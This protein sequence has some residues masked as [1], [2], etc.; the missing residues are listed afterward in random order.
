MFLVNWEDSAT[1]DFV[2]IC[3]DY[4][5]YWVD[6]KN[7]DAEID[8]KLRQDPVGQSVEVS[9]GLRRIISSP[10]V[11]FFSIDE[12]GVVWVQNVAWLKS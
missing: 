3:V 4:R 9:E 2:K 7:A 11:V 1:D 6:I 12:N 10:L 8:T 5:P